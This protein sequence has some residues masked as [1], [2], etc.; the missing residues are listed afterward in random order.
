VSVPEA[1]LQHNRDATISIYVPQL[2][3][4]EHYGVRWD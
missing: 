3:V 4:G 2:R 1:D